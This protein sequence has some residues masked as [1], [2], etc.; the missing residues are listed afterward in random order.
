MLLRSPKTGTYA[1]SSSP[2]KESDLEQTVVKQQFFD[3]PPFTDV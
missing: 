3:A 2:W 1:L